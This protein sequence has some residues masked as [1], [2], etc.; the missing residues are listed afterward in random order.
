MYLIEIELKY[1][2]YKSTKQQTSVSTILRKIKTAAIRAIPY[3]PPKKTNF[4][5]RCWRCRVQFYIRNCD[6]YPEN[7]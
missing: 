6:H 2:K 3:I 1:K 5:S 4:I 7:T